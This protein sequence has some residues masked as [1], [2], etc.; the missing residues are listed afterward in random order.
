MTPLSQA[1]FDDHQVRKSV[2]DKLAFIELLRGSIPELTVQTGG[3][4]KNRNVIVGNVET[5]KVLLTAHYDT[6]AWLP[7]PNF[8]TP[9]KPL[10]SILYSFVLII[11]MAAI[12]YLLNLVLRLLGA[13]FW[14]MY[15]ISLLIWFGLLALMMVG[16][17]NRHTANDNT[18]GVITLCEI[19]A[20]LSEAERPKVALVFFDNEETGLFGSSY[21]RK[22][23][24]KQTADKL[25]INFDCV[26]DGDHLLLAISKAARKEYHTALRKAFVSAGEKHFLLEKAEKVY[27]P[28][29]QAGFKKA[30]AVAALKRNRLLGYYIDRIH[31][32]RDT[33]FDEENIL[34]LR[35]R[36][37]SFL[38]AL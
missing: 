26:S 33:A 6:C 14:G 20:A 10:L 23:Y 7:I 13:S 24:K 12:I 30:I 1:I 17:A 8:I 31:T 2:K 15:W 35:D 38:K 21:F 37:L 3:F 28:S 36:T 32:H 19:Y 16:P 25:L 5:A 9:K 11:P 34:L 18:S 29:D 22:Q 4:P 27:Y